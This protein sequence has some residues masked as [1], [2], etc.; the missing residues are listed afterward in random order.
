VALGWFQH[1]QNEI[2]DEKLLQSGIEQLLARVD[3]GG[4]KLAAFGG[5]F[6]KPAR[7][8]YPAEQL[9]GYHHEE[10]LAQFNIH[11][12]RQLEQFHAAF[13]FKNLEQADGAAERDVR[14]GLHGQTTDACCRR[15]AVFRREHGLGD[16]RV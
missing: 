8:R 5:H 4:Q 15:G 6:N 2:E 9:G 1:P 3:G 16:Q 10:E 14:N 13:V 7:V 12:A 11:M